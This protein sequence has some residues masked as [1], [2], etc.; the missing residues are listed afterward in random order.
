MNLSILGV[1]AKD[2]RNSGK[3]HIEDGN[4]QPRIHQ[5]SCTLIINPPTSYSWQY[6]DWDLKVP[7]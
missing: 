6:M 2:K 4:R 7:E 1:E 3:V 5:S